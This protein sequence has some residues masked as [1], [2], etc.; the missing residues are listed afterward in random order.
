MKMRLCSKVSLSRN[1]D[2]AGRAAQIAEKIKPWTLW[3]IHLEK[4]PAG[5]LFHGVGVEGVEGQPPIGA[6]IATEWIKIYFNAS[7]KRDGDIPQGLATFP[8]R[9]LNK[10]RF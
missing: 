6:L 3:R 1:R 5:S 2:V 4:S 7:E 8:P 9:M 10:K